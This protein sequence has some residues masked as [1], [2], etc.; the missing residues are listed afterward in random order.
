M[1]RKQPQTAK[2]M[3]AIPGIGEARVKQY[4]E[5]FLSFFLQ[6]ARARDEKTEPLV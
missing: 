4:G 3:L 2:D 6:E 1:V 5:T